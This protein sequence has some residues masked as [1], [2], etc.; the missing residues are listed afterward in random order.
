MKKTLMALAAVAAMSGFCAHMNDLNVTLTINETLTYNNGQPVNN[1]YV[2]F[3]WTPAGESFGGFLADGR[4]VGS[5]ILLTKVVV[6]NGRFDKPQAFHIN[7]D[8]V[9]KLEIERGT[10]SLYLLDTRG[11][12]GNLIRSVSEDGVVRTG[13]VAVN[14]SAKLAETAECASSSVF[15]ESSGTVNDTIV[16]S[17]TVDLP[18]L[19]TEL[20]PIIKSAKVEGDMFV[21]TIE[22]AVPYMKYDLIDASSKKAIGD[23]AKSGVVTEI[24]TLKTSADAPSKLI[25]VSAGRNQ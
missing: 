9:E 4:I 8:L 16:A 3:V 2:A 18:V 10:F 22:K 23:S 24:I 19:E 14:Y 21:V 25:Q 6:H 15:G 7:A 12:D 1:E 17:G 13:L 20:T 5:S 11:A